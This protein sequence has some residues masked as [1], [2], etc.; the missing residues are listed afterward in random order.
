MYY[1]TFMV[2]EFDLSKTDVII[3]AKLEKSKYFH[4]LIMGKD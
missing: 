1:D 3:T 2:R 4:Y